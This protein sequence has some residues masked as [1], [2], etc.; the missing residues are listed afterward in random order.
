MKKNALKNL[1]KEVLSEIYNEKELSPIDKKITDQYKIEIGPSLSKLNEIYTDIEETLN[2]SLKTLKDPNT[3]DEQWDKEYNL[4]EL[5][6]NDLLK[7]MLDSGYRTEQVSKLID[8][9]ENTLEGN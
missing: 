8:D 4:L 2:F 1:I 7:P 3:S 9:I 5:L 6:K